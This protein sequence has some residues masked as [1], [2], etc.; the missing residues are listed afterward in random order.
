MN[1]LNH[2][3]NNNLHDKEILHTRVQKLNISSEVL[4]EKE[5]VL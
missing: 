3:Y 2:K 5:K 1:E 4:K